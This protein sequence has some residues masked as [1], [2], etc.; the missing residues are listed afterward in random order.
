MQRKEQDDIIPEEDLKV[1][2]AYKNLFDSDFG[3]MVLDDLRVEY[4]SGSFVPGDPY[5]TAYNEGQRSVVLALEA[6][7]SMELP[8]QINADEEEKEVDAT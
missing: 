6:V 5:Y 2:K 3:R 4:C 1:I 7:L 8:E